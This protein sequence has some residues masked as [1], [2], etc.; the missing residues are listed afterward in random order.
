MVIGLTFLP[1][2]AHT[3]N[4]IDDEMK[5]GV[6]DHDVPIG[7]DHKECCV[8]AGDEILFTSPRVL[9]WFC[10]PRPNLGVRMGFRF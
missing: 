6:L 5:L 3:R 2:A 8:D 7:G 4:G 1:S 10:A 9:I